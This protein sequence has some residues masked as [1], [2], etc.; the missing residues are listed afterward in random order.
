MATTVEVKKIDIT[1][2]NTANIQSFGYDEMLK[3]HYPFDKAK[4]YQMEIL[5]KLQE[6]L[7]IPLF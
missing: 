1:D 4:Q 6:F 2:L 7:E 3:D 5:D